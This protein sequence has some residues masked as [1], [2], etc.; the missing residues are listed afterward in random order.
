MSSLIKIVSFITKYLVYINNSVGPIS[1]DFRNL[2]LDRE[3]LLLCPPDVVHGVDSPTVHGDR[4]D[5]VLNTQALQL[6][7]F[8]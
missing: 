5:L 7:N 1:H 2:R 4:L 8:L 3:Q 6:L